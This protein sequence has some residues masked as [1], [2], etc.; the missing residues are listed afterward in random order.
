MKITSVFVLATALGAYAAPR[1]LNTRNVTTDEFGLRARQAGQS[2]PGVALGG[3]RVA[4]PAARPD[5]RARRASTSR[6]TRSVT[7][8]MKEEDAIKARDPQRGGS[9]GPPPPPPRGGGG[10]GGAS[11]PAAGGGRGGAAPSPPG[12]APPGGAPGGGRGGGGGASGGAGAP[13]PGGG[14]GGG[15]APPPGGRPFRRSED[16]HI[17]TYDGIDSD[18]VERETFPL[19]EANLAARDAQI[20]AQDFSDNDSVFSND[21]TSSILS[22]DDNDSLFSVDSQ[23]SNPSGVQARSPQSQPPPSRGAARPLPPPRGVSGARSPIPP[24]GRPFRA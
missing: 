16:G 3:G 21:D 14:R 13:P 12:G 20:E 10:R 11:P 15:G 23:R 18:I 5:G 6:V 1:T 22:N 8:V 7:G 24:P 4:F 17:S 19:T 9:T 2:V